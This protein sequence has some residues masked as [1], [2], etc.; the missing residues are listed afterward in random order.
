MKCVEDRQSR[1]Y[2]YIWCYIPQIAILLIL[3]F[4]PSIGVSYIIEFSIGLFLASTISCIRL[5]MA[6][7]EKSTGELRAAILAVYVVI[8]C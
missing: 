3:L 5:V 6:F 7:G 8:C 2:Y 4:A 1:N